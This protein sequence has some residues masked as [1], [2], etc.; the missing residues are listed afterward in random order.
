MTDHYLNT[1]SPENYT[2]NGTTGEFSLNYERQ[3]TPKDHLTMIASHELARYAIPNEL[4]QQN[5]AYVPNGDNTDGCSGPDP[6]S[7]NCV[8]IPGG[9]LQTNDNFE[10]MGILSY[11]HIFSP[12]TMVAMRGMARDNS[13]DFYSNPASWPVNVT[14]R[15]DF[16]D[17]YF[18]ARA[19]HSDRW[20]PS[21][22]TQKNS[23]A[24]TRSVTWICS[25]LRP[26]ARSSL[27]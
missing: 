27:A 7:D 21:S 20:T 16:K 15:N 19:T 24:I 8:Y 10:T 22:I 6:A 2:N 12:D 13:L 18:N 3:F 14:Q 26:I 5:G 1:P 25:W 23:G 4:V 9:Q 11:E 17:I